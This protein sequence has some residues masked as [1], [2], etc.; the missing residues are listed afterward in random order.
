M[1]RSGPAQAETNSVSRAG[2]S[3]RPGVREV[4][5][6]KDWLVSGQL[7][8]IDFS[9]AFSIDYDPALPNDP[10]WWIDQVFSHPPKPVSAM[11]AIRNAAMAPFGL[12]HSKADP[13]DG[14]PAQLFETFDANEHEVVMGTDDKH[15]NFRANILTGREGE[16]CTLT[17]ATVVRFN[18]R[19]GRA[20]F[21]PVKPIHA[22]VVV[23]MTLRHAVRVAEKSLAD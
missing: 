21:I 19:F 17:M 15:L 20:Y 13:L 16:R 10:Q 6:D 2:A 12:K 9:D 7:D 14:K 4:P 1:Q 3:P 8:R 11:L 18:N 22:R 5:V 23:P